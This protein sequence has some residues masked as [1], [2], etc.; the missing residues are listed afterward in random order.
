[1]EHT[2]IAACISLLIGCGLKDAG[3]YE[4]VDAVRRLLPN[5]SFAIM[6]DVIT[7]LK[8]FSNLAVSLL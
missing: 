5:A 7:K 4:Q 8:E 3:H 1:M 2:I 6:I